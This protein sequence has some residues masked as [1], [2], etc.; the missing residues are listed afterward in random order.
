VATNQDVTIVTQGTWS[1]GNPGLSM[2]QLTGFAP[3][4]SAITAQQTSPS[5]F[6]VGVTIGS[7]TVLN[8][9]SALAGIVDSTNSAWWDTAATGNTGINTIEPFLDQTTFSTLLPAASPGASSSNLFQGGTG[10]NTVTISGDSKRFMATFFIM[11][12]GMRGGKPYAGAPMGLLVALN[13]GGTIY[14]FYNPGSFSGNSQWR[15]I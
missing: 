10:T 14:K 6:K 2:C 13:N 9:S 15:R 7:A 3:T 12:V 11:V 8:R 4:T 5:T 1:T